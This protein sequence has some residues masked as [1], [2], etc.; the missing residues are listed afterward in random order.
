[1]GQILEPETSG[2]INELLRGVPKTQ[3]PLEIDDIRP[4]QAGRGFH[5]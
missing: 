5:I 2:I 4:K 3:M 1:M